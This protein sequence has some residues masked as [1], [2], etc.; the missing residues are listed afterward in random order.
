M[1][2]Y[3]VKPEA[4]GVYNGRRYKG[5]VIA[6]DGNIKTVARTYLP[7]V[8]HPELGK[9]IALKRFK[10]KVAREQEKELEEYYDTLEHAWNT[11]AR[12]MNSIANKIVNKVNRQQEL[13]CELFDLFEEVDA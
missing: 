4:E 8:F 7:D 1:I 3:Y 12:E 5:M 13:R 2:Q 6:T 10:I 9:Q 11:I